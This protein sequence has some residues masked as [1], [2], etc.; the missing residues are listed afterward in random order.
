MTKEEKEAAILDVKCSLVAFTTGFMPLIWTLLTSADFDWNSQFLW[1]IVL[2][3]ISTVILGKL[4]FPSQFGI[5]WRSA[6]TGL[7][8][9]F[10]IFVILSTSFASFGLYFCLLSFFHYCEYSVTGLT[11]PSNLSTDSFLLNHSIQYWIAA[12]ASWI[13]FWLQAYFV[14]DLKRVKFLIF[15]GVLI[16]I[17]GDVLRKLAM[18]HAGNSF[19]H[20]V[21]SSK[22]D[23]HKLVTNG[24]FSKFRHPSYVGWF[25]WSLGTQVLLANPLCLTVYTWVSWSFFNERIYIE[26]YSLLQF[27]GQA[28]QDYQRKVPVGI[29]FIKGFQV[30]P[31]D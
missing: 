10:G 25:T 28:Y 14:P 20:I 4:M 31:D 1:R 9:T 30:E 19:S 2:S 23:D 13:E 29:P 11:N 24:V 27:F 21:Q 17:F 16:C 12:I 18:F 7:G 6:L 22:K 3:M 5:W 15:A 8:V 26:E